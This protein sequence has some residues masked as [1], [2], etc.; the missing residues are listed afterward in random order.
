MS[1]DKELS[2]I[3][4]K[5]KAGTADFEDMQRYSLRTAEI[6]AEVLKENLSSAGTGRNEEAC[7]Q[8][9]REQHED[10]FQKE[11]AV[12]KTLDEKQ[13]IHI[14]PKKPKFPAERV[15]KAAHSLEDKTVSEEV[16]QR[17]A[18]NA[19]ANI[20]NSFHDDY[21]KENAEFRQNAGLKCHVTRIGAFE[22]CAW[23]AEVAGRY[24]VGK[25]PAD[26]WRRHDHCSCRMDYENQKVRQRLSGTGKGWKVDSETQ[27]RQAQR[28]QYKPK[29]F[30]R[31]EAK[32][33]EQ[34]KLSRIK[35][36]TS[37]GR[38][39]M[40]YSLFRQIE[41]NEINP[42]TAQRAIRFNLYQ[43]TNSKNN[44]YVSEGARND[45]VK[46]KELHKI[47]MHLSEVYKIMNIEKNENLPTVY[48]VNEAEMNSYA[49]ASYNAILNVLYLSR[50]FAIYSGGNVPDGM[51]QFS[52]H[53]DD[54]S[55][56][57]H[58][59]YH[60][61]DAEKFRQ[62]YG[63]VTQENYGDYVDFINQEAKKKLD[64]LVKKGYNINDSSD[65]GKKEYQNQKYYET[66]T[67]YRV[68]NLLEE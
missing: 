65:Y 2:A 57:V 51:E 19:V 36:L 68:T 9:L 50:K 31:E 4:K 38:S 66:Y 5:M 44:I 18:E 10:V 21:I 52:C 54:R 14:E 41:Y 7:I 11:S 15:R 58:E 32:A 42:I 60:W 1:A 47:D 59:L 45:R 34:Q 16:I 37:A 53:K 13:N 28:I 22:C 25:E 24:E 12:Q 43:V 26:F 29:R 6:R 27:R 61:L 3:L 17:R 64:K 30:S 62:K 67:E 8:I 33:L 48:V 49:A 20:A 35:G 55:S 56:Y 46:P 23:C 40:E 63:Q 39:D